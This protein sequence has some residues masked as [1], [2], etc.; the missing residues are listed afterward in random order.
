MLSGWLL[1]EEWKLRA[2]LILFLLGALF[3]FELISWKDVL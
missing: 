1:P 3:I 2:G